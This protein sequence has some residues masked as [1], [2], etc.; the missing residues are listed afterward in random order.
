MR[1]FRLDK[2]TIAALAATFREYLNEEEACENIPVLKM[3]SRSTDEL[4][5]QAHG[6]RLGNL[7]TEPG[8]YGYG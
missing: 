8:K 2:C 7:L 3:L 1:A 5:A 4:W 6:N